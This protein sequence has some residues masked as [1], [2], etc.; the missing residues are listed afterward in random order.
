M[1]TRSNIGKYIKISSDYQSDGWFQVL[2]NDCVAI[3]RHLRLKMGEAVNI[4]VFHAPGPNGEIPTF[5]E[6]QPWL[7]SE[8]LS[9]FDA[10]QQI[11]QKYPGTYLGWESAARS[12]ELIQAAD[13]IRG[14]PDAAPLQALCKTIGDIQLSNWRFTEFNHSDMAQRKDK[15]LHDTNGRARAWAEVKSLLEDTLAVF[16][17][18]PG[19]SITLHARVFTDGSYEPMFDSTAGN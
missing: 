16:D 9:R 4:P 8:L 5:R 13:L 6:T 14:L 19:R 12:Q 2:H 10:E 7:A 18:V 17:G 3:K 1:I 15:K 11:I